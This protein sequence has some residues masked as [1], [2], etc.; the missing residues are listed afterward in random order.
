MGIGAYMPVSLQKHHATPEEAIRIANNIGAKIIIPMHFGTF[1]L[2]REPMNEP[3][4]RFRSAM[5]G[6]LKRIGLQE[7]GY[8]WV[9][10]Y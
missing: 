4:Q 5:S 9:K 3:I 8:T 10:P 6:E 1:R 7:I 2:S